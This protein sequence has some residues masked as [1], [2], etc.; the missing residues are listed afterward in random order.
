MATSLIAF[1]ASRTAAAVVYAEL[2]ED[3]A[4][5]IWEIGAKR[6]A[7]KNPTPVSDEQLE[8]IIDR[9]NWKLSVHHAWAYSP[10][11]FPHINVLEANAANMAMDWA[12]KNFINKTQVVI[13]TDS[14]D[15][16]GAYNK[17]R[18]PLQ[19]LLQKIRRYQ[20]TSLLT[21]I[22]PILIHVR[23]KHNPADPP[24]RE[25]TRQK[26]QESLTKLS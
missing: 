26:V 18:P 24:S 19:W 16:I 8:A 7:Q 4:T 25:K 13:L 14:G 1:D 12:S 11:D 3:E 22:R 17:G 6:K 20:A 21:G 5:T 15:V 9:K 2:D 23:T 10:E